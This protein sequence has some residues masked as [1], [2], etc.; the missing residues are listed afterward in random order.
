MK[1]TRMSKRKSAERP[2]I[3]VKDKKY[4]K[5]QFEAMKDLMF[6]IYLKREKKKMETVYLKSGEENGNQ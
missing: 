4:S 3:K 1:R 2:F 6:R 5:K